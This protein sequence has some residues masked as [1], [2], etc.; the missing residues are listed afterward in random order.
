VLTCRSVQHEVRRTW[1]R[2][3]DTM[4]YLL[5]EVNGEEL[6]DEVISNGDDVDAC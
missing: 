4:K 5:N 6:A 3:L 1:L 2:Q